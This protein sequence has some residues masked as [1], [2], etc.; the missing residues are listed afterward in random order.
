ME[1]ILKFLGKRWVYHTLIWLPFILLIHTTFDVVLPELKAESTIT[2]TYLKVYQILFLMLV[3]Y[4]HF[5]IKDYFI[6]QKKYLVY[7]ICTILFIIICAL[8]DF[9]IV[10]SFFKRFDEIIGNSYIEIIY[11][12]LISTGLQFFK[13]SVQKIIR[14]EKNKADTKEIELNSLKA[15][16]NPHFLFNNLNNIY[17]INQIDSEKGSEMILEL[18]DLLRYHL[19]LSEK[20]LIS[21]KDEIKIINSYI[22]LEKLRLNENCKLN[23]D[24]SS[25]EQPLYIAPLILIPFIENAFKHGT[26]PKKDC[27]I[28]ICLNAEDKE[29]IL[30]VK[31]SRVYNEK[32]VKT[33]IGLEN[34]KKRLHILYPNKHS[35]NIENGLNTYKVSLNIEL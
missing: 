33:N 28:D 7:A 21:L 19:Q 5:F 25:P 3:V 9:V 8:M 31:N 1:K 11:I 24:I 14:E 2:K 22:L 12:I 27:F 34:T 26:H 6:K 15:Q 16:I 13:R 30:V 20:K 32:I 35:L 18:S 4:G 10:D 17:A 23:I 29:L